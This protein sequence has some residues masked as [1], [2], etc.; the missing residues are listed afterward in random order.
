MKGMKNEAASKGLVSHKAL[1]EYEA[2]TFDFQKD[3]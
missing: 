3:S 1:N 2:T